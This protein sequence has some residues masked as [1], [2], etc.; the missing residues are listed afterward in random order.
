[1]QGIIP[2]SVITI[3]TKSE[4]VTSYIKLRRFSESNSRQ[5]RSVSESVAC[6]SGIRS[7][8]SPLVRLH[9]VRHKVYILIHHESTVKHAV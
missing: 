7:S 9:K 4:G 3:E 5:L 6:W 1:M 8:G 2:I